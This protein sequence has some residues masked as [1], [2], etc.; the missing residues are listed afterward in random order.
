MID[1]RK[2][3]LEIDLI[4]IDTLK[5]GTQWLG[6]SLVMLPIIEARYVINDPLEFYPLDCIVVMVGRNG[7]IKDP[8]NPGEYF[9]GWWKE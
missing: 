8:A 5:K 1:Q 2:K 3:S 7:D 4:K 9:E 6:A